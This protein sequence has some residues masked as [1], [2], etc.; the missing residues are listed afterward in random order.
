MPKVSLVPEWYLFAQALGDA[1]GYPKSLDERN[2]LGFSYEMLDV[3]HAKILETKGEG[4]ELSEK[5]MILNSID[6]ALHYVDVDIPALYDISEDELKIF[7]DDLEMCWGMKS[8][9]GEGGSI[10]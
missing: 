6:G 3:L 2:A 7:K 10:R 5:Q 8:T 9:Y 1:K 4:L